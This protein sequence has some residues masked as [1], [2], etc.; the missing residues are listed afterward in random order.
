VSASSPATEKIRCPWRSTNAQR[1]VLITPTG[2]GITRSRPEF[3]A[4]CYASG[5]PR[6]SGEEP[7]PAPAIVTCYEE[8]GRLVAGVPDFPGDPPPIPPRS[9]R[10]EVSKGQP[11]PKPD[12]IV[13][14]NKMVEPAPAPTARP[15]NES[16]PA[17]GSVC[18][19][20]QVAGEGPAFS[21][22]A[23]VAIVTAETLEAIVALA[24]F[25]G[26]GTDR[27]AAILLNEYVKELRDAC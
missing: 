13:E 8:E 10:P 7:R 5:C 2:C 24:E 1:D 19:I 3:S 20:A 25:E 26:E 4:K 14:P 18:E 11:K 23:L 16:A 21:F 9:V 17:E 15:V 6:L 27:M 12:H 22:R